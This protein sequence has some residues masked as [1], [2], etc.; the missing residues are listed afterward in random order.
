MASSSTKTKK[1]GEDGKTKDGE[2][3]EVWAPTRGAT[4][5]ITDDS[6]ESFVKSLV[7]KVSRS[8]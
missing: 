1:G 4:V 7:Y 6:E 8:R 5:W 2:K 3:K